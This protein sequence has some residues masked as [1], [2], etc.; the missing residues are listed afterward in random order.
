[1]TLAAML[2]C[3]TMAVNAKKKVVIIQPTTPIIRPQSP[4]Q[5]HVAISGEYGQDELTLHFTGYD[6]DA[7]VTIVDATTH[8]V[9]SIYSETIASPACCSVDISTLPTSTYYIF[10]E[11]GNGDC[12]YGFIR[13]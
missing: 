13:I 6:G 1:M 4:Q 9:V 8:Q 10:I 2:L 5:D 12:Y 3:M 11:L 7:T